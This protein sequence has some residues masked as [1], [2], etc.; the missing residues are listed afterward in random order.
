MK[1]RPLLSFV[2]LVLCCIACD[3]DPDLLS[4]ALEQPETALATRNVV[5]QSE[6]YQVKAKFLDFD[7]G[8]LDHYLFEDE[9]G[10]IWDFAHI[11]NQETFELKQALPKHLHNDFNKG[12]DGNDLFQEKWF[13]LHCQQDQ[14]PLY[15]GGPV[16]EVAVVTEA[17]LLF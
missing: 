3:A 7:R 13:L 4:T 9:Q 14:Q 8:D 15:D 11:A 6:T 16:G 12:W 2:A 5:N 10:K 1:R 17:T